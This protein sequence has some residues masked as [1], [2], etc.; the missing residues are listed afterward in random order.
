MRKM[1]GCLQLCCLALAAA[2]SVVAQDKATM[3]PPKVLVITREYLKPGKAGAPHEKTE[4]LFVSA[5]TAAK[6]EEH[7]LAMDS[8]T[9]PS[10]S[11]FLAGYDSFESWEKDNLATL[12]NSAYS[13]ALSKAA[14]ADGELLTAIETTAF[15][16][17]DDLSYQVNDV[18]I[19]KMR[20]FDIARFKVKPGHM[21][22]WEELGKMYKDNFGKAVPDAHWAIYE[23]AYGK[24]SSGIFIVMT[25]MK[26]LSEVDKGYGDSK[27]F[28]DSLGEDGVK[29]LHE[30]MNASAEFLEDNLFY[31]NPAESYPRPE[32]IKSDPDFWKPKAAAAEKKSEKK[33][34]P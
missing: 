17:H 30:L 31:F 28:E 22:E 16:Y 25:P 6:W 29:K 7:Y 18:D 14:V 24:D 11:L 23:D 26:S 4:S 2:G 32:W 34:T 19:A 21:K 8:M 10:R 9:G 5:A 33:A 13:A 1:I 12:K 27:K 3:G 20:Y 15:V